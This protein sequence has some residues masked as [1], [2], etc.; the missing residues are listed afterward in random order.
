MRDCIVEIDGIGEKSSVD[1]KFHKGVN[2]HG[3]ATIKCIV[4]EDEAD[5][6]LN[7]STDVT[8]VSIKI[9]D[10]GKTKAEKTIFSGIISEVKVGNIRGITEVEMDLIGSSILMD[11]QPIT[12]T[13]QMDDSK[14]SE[15]ILYLTEKYSKI[16][17]NAGTECKENTDPKKDLLVQY[18]ETDY[19]FLKRCASM[20]GLPLLTS[21]NATDDKI[22]NVTIGL[23]MD[24]DKKELKSKYYKQGKQFL[25]Y[26]NKKKH[27]LKNI[28]EDDY[29]VVEVRSRDY[30]DI[31][32]K[33][34]IDGKTLYV[35][36]VDSVYDS[37]LNKTNNGENINKDEFWHNYILAGEKRFSEAIIYNYDMIGASLQAKVK[38]VNEYKVEVDTDVDT[39]NETQASKNVEFPF[40]T[41]YST[42]DGT[43]WYCMP[44]V[45][46][47]VRLY[48]P[49]EYED[50]AYV[51]SAVHLKEKNGLRD[52]PE[53]KFIMNKYKKMVEFSKDSIRITNNDGMEIKLDDSK[54]ISIIS[55]KDISLSAAKEINIVSKND[56][57]N[58]SG[59]SS[60]ML[61]QG[62]S[63]YLELKGKATVKATSVHI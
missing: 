43:G 7:L 63:A 53:K 47:V 49:T 24:G 54:G 44:E 61:K 18:N 6:L 37:S 2:E 59:K 40:A 5:K 13:Y 62:T 12:R 31:G 19:S 45:G 42:N 57:V 52:K 36:S 30:F 56:E 60:V 38:K 55:N 46:D 21:I 11:L 20:Q 33:V 29:S 1:I 51:I 8:W 3:N 10:E 39:Q 58:V 48:F 25:E 28:K 15:V 9:G 22:I 41:V 50:D 35:Y 16:K 32:E 4:E 27:G 14:L 17:I 34:I 23:N 26:I